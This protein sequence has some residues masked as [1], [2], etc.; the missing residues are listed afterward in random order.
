[1]NKTTSRQISRFVAAMAACSFVACSSSSLDPD[2]NGPGGNEGDS[3]DG[4]GPGDGDD[5]GSGCLDCVDD[6]FL[7]LPASGGVDFTLHAGP[8]TPRDRE[9][10]VSFGVPLPQG[11]V[12]SATDLAI[13]DAAGNELSTHVEE[14]AR[15]RSIIDPNDEGSLRSA[16]V[17]LRVR[18]DQDEVPLQL[19]WGANRTRE[20]GAQGDPLATWISVSEPDYPVALSEPAAWAVFPT[21]W[22]SGS[23]LRTRTLDTDYQEGWEWFDDSFVNYAATAVNDVPAQV[24]T[25]IDYG[26][27]DE[28]WL[29]DRASALFGVYVRTGEFKWLR[30]AH[31]AARYY[32]SHLSAGG[33]FDLKA[34]DDLKYSYGQSMMV[35][36]VL[37]GTTDL[38]PVIESVAVAGADWKEVYTPASNFWTERHQSYSLLAAISAWEA[39]G[40][41]DYAAR[42]RQIVTASLAQINAPASSWP[43]NG[44]VLHTLEDH[45][46]G[47]GAVPACSTWMSALLSE[48]VWRYYLQSRDHDALELMARLA[49]FIVA[50]GTYDGSSE[51]LALIV[52]WYLSSSMT[53]FSDSGPWGDM[54][55]GCDVAGLVARGAWARKQLGGSTDPFKQTLDD[56]LETCEYSLNYWHRPGGPAAGLAEWRLSPPRKFNWWFGSTLDMSWFARNL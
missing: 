21:G 55:H 31:R 23:L 14:T 53:Q 43:V 48:A 40:N 19:R 54:E 52:P 51:N 44:C 15:W 13:H 1:M 18:F 30:R 9:V 38:V 28:P 50:Y 12:A 42:A 4:E 46:G 2:R 24:T 35:D 8:S 26:T 49:E 39:T 56:M 7:D 33:Y 47:G 10:L 41:A 29:Y 16:V 37:A 3:E 6:L 22:L 25:R 20:L 34:Y 32:A 5:P 45:E 27:V 17:W 36:Q 11:T